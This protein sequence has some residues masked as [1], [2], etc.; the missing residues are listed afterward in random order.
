MHDGASILDGSIVGFVNVQDHYLL[1][2]LRKTVLRPASGGGECLRLDAGVIVVG[3]Y[4]QILCV[5]SI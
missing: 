2:M 1:E 5:P 3:L 4:V